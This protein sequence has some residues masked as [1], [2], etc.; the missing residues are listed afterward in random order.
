MVTGLAWVM[1]LPYHAQ[2]SF[3]LAMV[4]FSSAFLLPMLPG[5]PYLWEF[6]ALLA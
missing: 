3:S 2:V 6:A 5:R 1:L 4:T